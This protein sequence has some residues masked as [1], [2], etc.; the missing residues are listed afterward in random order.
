MQKKFPIL[1]VSNSIVAF[2][3]PR[4]T[5]NIMKTIF[6]QKAFNQNSVQLLQNYIPVKFKSIFSK[7]SLTVSLSFLRRNPLSMWTATTRST[8]IAL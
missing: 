6:Y 8:P 5:M 4:F 7:D 2:L 1:F 3:D